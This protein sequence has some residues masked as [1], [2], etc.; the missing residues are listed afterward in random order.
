MSCNFFY[1][2]GN[3]E[4]E[5]RDIGIKVDKVLDASASIVPFNSPKHL[6]RHLKKAISTHHLKNYPDRNHKLLKEAISKWH[7]IS[8]DMILPGNGASELFTWAAHD[9]SKY[10]T[11]G[12]LSPGFSDYSRALNCWDAS[13]LQ[14]PIPLIWANKMAQKFPVIPKTKVLWIT[15]PHNP[16][17]Q[18]WSRESIEPLIPNYQLIICDEAFLDLVPNGADESLLPLTK[19]YSNLIVIKSLTK[20]F[21]IAGLRLGYAIGSPERL[22]NWKRLRDPWPV[23]GLAISAGIKLI[24]E[25]KELNAW[26]NK[27]HKWINKEGKWLYSQLELIPEIMPL[28]SSTNFLLIKGNFPLINIRKKLKERSILTRDC[29]SFEGLNEYYLRISLQKRKGNKKIISNLK[30]IIRS[31]E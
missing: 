10:G 11:S 23:N 14:I 17:G 7:N 26:I 5:A 27:I 15:N 24:S 31:N 1:H 16:T 8:P 4:E 20:L 13:Y 30:E 22:L 6:R 21:S 12:L 25:E 28:T 18:L 29:R 9:A 19:K 3:L 2:G